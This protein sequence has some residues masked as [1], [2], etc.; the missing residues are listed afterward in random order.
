MRQKNSRLKNKLTQLG[1]EHGRL[2][3]QLG[4]NRKSADE[5]NRMLENMTQKERS[6]ERRVGKECLFRCRS[7]W[8]PYH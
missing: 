2:G 7:R 8:S 3:S 6:E 4:R 5:L 1:Y